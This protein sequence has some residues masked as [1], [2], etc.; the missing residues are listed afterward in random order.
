VNFTRPGLLVGMLL[1]FVAVPSFATPV[2]IPLFNGCPQVGQALGCSSLMDYGSVNIAIQNNSASSVSLAG[3]SNPNG[4]FTSIH[5]TAVLSNGISSYFTWA[6]SGGGGDNKDCD[7][8]D[9]DGKSCKGD[10]DDKDSDGKGC[11]D[12]DDGHKNVTPEPASIM[13]LGTGLVFLGGIVRRKLV[14]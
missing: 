10:C 12:D 3:Y 11:G 8:K 14:S 4:N 1:L 2:P 5:S 7:G 13:L 9:S 6:P